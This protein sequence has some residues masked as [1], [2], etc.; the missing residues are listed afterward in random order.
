MRRTPLLGGAVA[1]CLAVGSVACS[2][3]DGDKSEAEVTEELSES[4]QE[5]GDGLDK[6]TADCFAEI[7]VETVGVDELQDVDLT[8]DEPPAELQDEITAAAAE[9]VDECD[10]SGLSG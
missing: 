7:I 10:L 5:G 3:D 8:A 6:E 1:L 2:G 4:L 9:A